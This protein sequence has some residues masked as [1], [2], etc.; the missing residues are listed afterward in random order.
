MSFNRRGVP[1]AS[2][3]LSKLDDAE[4]VRIAQLQLPYVTSAYEE[5]FNR[6]FKQVYHV[7][8]RYLN[9]V[10]EA[11]ECANDTMLKVFNNLKRYEERANFKTWLFRIAHN[12]CMSLL[13]KKQLDQVS[14][15]EAM[16]IESS[17]IAEHG[18]HSSSIELLL[19][20][21][22]IDDRSIIIFR[23]I[24]EL[25]FQQISDITGLKLSTVKMRCKRA[26][27]KLNL[28]SEQKN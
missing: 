11:E 15:D 2:L 3:N 6:Y 10:E 22:S 5:L 4:L 17:P 21:L 9:S 20:Q 26:L 1:A 7:C 18:A 27:E 13:R 12:L 16:E 28:I 24:S 23:V 8:Y 25:E 19:N 14:I